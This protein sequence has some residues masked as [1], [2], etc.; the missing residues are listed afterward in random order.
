MAKSEPM[1]APDGCTYWCEGHL[2]DRAN[3]HCDQCMCKC[4]HRWT[5]EQA[6]HPHRLTLHLSDLGL[7]DELVAWLR[8]RIDEGGG[9]SA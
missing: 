7:E 5:R 3:D 9:V 4:A 6:E 1:T 8:H 2:C